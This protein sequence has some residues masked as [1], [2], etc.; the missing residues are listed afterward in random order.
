MKRTSLYDE[1]KKLEAKFTEFSGWEMPVQYTS[2]ID[3]HNAVRANVGMFDTS[4][5]GTFI[6]SGNDIEKF[7]NYVT[8]GNMS[9]LPDRKARYSMLLNEEG[10]IKDDVIVY[11]FG[12]EY[13][14]VVNAGNLDKDFEW[15]NKHKSESINIRNI[16]EDIS[17]LAV[18]GPKAASILQSISNTYI[19]SMKYFTVSELKLKDIA[20]DF[21]RIARTGYTGEDGFEIFISKDK[22][23]ELW[24][25]LI[26]LSVKPC[27]LGCRDT[28][29]LE[30]C[31]PLHGHEID[32]NINPLEAGF[33]KTINW[34][35][36]FIGKDKLIPLKD[37][38]LRKSV[39]FE[40]L[41][42]IARNSN[43]VFLGDKKIGYVTS[44]S[45]SPILKRAIGMAL[46]ESDVQSDN[47]EVAIHNNRRKIKI[48]QKPFYKRQK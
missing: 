46:I 10:G 13:M 2:I 9:G 15:L 48:V 14:I 45:F 35:N 11:K 24:E 32:E 33:Q 16:S 42:G 7:L 3:E 27:G 26:N 22:T 6:F 41:S 37:K 40:C 30:S 5:M 38:P 4:H 20:A 12:N 34:D 1:H 29:R 43:E 28:L 19:T 31:M 39:A 36:D 23:I 21:C 17:L 8:L 25:K 47:L 44:G 18:Q